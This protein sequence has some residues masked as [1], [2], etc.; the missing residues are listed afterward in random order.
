MKERGE[1]ESEDVYVCRNI[2]KHN[3]GARFVHLFTFVNT[4]S[5]VLLYSPSVGIVSYR[6]ELHKFLT[7]VQI[8]LSP[9]I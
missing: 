6:C 4:M 2:D 1:N 7:L 5:I 9:G 8:A 3:I